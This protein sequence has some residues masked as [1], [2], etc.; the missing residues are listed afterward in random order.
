[1]NA[2]APPPP[3]APAAAPRPIAWEDPSLTSGFDQFAQTVKGL[4]TAPGD[5][6]RSMPI[7][8]GIGRPLFYA[9]VVSWIGI[10][11]AIIWNVL[12]QS[13]WMPFMDMGD[14]L[15]MAVGFTAVWA[16]GT[17]VIAP[18]FIL[19]GIFIAAGI[20]HL[21]LL[22]V[23]AANSGFEA[24]VRVVCYAQTA[25]LANAI[26]MCGG[27]VSMVWALILYI[28]GLAAGQR[29]THGKAA[30]AVLLPGILCCILSTFMFIAVMGMIAAQAQ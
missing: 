21:M 18:I 6:F 2:T 29:T 27:L 30:L 24:T 11:I 20:L 26:P 23:G 14:E 10:A 17:I 28:V 22:L 1:M 13:M 12:F 5:T 16:V 7:A 9:V 25:Q 8:G 19:I 15:G 4:A 3:A